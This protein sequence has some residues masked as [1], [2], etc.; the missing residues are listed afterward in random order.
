MLKTKIARDDESG[1][2]LDIMFSTRTADLGVMYW[3]SSI[4][5]PFS[6]HIGVRQDFNIASFLERNTER[7][8]REISR[9][10]DEFTE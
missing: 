8:E 4:T 10:V 3:M 6:A 2:M 1:E 5:N 9:A 7:I